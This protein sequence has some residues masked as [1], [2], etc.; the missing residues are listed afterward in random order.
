[1]LGGAQGIF[2]GADIFGGVK[3]LLNAL[4]FFCC[5][6][7]FFCFAELFGAGEGWGT[8]KFIWKLKHFSS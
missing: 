5:A 1:M 8:E 4:K 7:E 2:L 6:E 3:N